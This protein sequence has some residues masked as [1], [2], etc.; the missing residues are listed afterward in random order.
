MNRPCDPA[1]L[2]CSVAG[3]L[4]EAGSSLRAVLSVRF[5]AEALV[6]SVAALLA[7][8]FVAAII[9]NPIF[10]RSIPPE[11]FAIAVWLLSAP[12]MG[13]I[14]ATYGRAARERAAALAPPSSGLLVSLGTVGTAVEAASEG[15]GTT[16]ATIGSLAAFLAIGCPVCNKVALLL[17]GAS[18]ALTVF[19]PLQPLIGAASLLLLAGTL[20]WRL[21]LLARGAACAAPARA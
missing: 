10:G 4:H 18:G 5:V 14:G 7:F 2:A 20:V 12:L 19:A 17:L 21:R 11:P 15:R 1:A 16:A 6:W 9:P 3:S 8:G 13:L